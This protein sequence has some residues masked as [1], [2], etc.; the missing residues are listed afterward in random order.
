MRRI[1]MFLTVLALAGVAFAGGGYNQEVVSTYQTVTNTPV[2]VDVSGLRG[3][4]I[5]IKVDAAVYAP[6]S[7]VSVVAIPEDTTFAT[8]TLVSVQTNMVAEVVARP[9]FDATDNEAAALTSDPPEPFVAYRDD[10]RLTV[11]TSAST[12]LV[13]KMLVKWLKID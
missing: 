10:I 1:A 2:T 5:E 11:D 13:Y 7:L 4:V 9:R 3:Q 12:N 6:T 8:V